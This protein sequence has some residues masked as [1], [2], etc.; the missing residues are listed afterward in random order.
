[1]IGIGEFPG[2]IF[3]VMSIYTR[4]FALKSGAVSVNFPN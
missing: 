1:M 2:S 4:F 3:P